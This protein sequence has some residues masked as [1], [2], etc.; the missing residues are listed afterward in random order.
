MK[1][2]V[3][4]I[5]YL[6]ILTFFVT[7]TVFAIVLSITQ[8]VKLDLD[9]LKK[10]QTSVILCYSNGEEIKRKDNNQYVEFRDIPSHVVNSLIAIEDKRFYSHRGVDAKG[11]FRALKNNLFTSSSKQGG[12]TITQQLVK[13][14][15]LSGEKTINRKLKEMRLAVEIERKLT[16]EQILE[17]YLNTVYFG[18]GAYGIAS[19]SNRFFNKN[20][21]ELTIEEGAVLIA[22]LKAPSIYSP[23]KN[24][25]KSKQRRDL[26]LSETY[27][28]GFISEKEYLIAKNKDIIINYERNYEIENVLY[29]EILQDALTVLKLNDISELNGYKI[30]SSI[31]K[32]L[33]NSIKSPADFGIDCDYSIIVTDNKK[34]EVVCYYSNVGDI[35]RCPASTAKPWLIY[36]PAIEENLICPATKILDEKTSFDGYAPSN[37]NDKYYGYVSVKDSLAKSLNIPSIKICNALGTE[38]VKEYAKKLDIEYL[39]N[40]LSVAL[41]NL[42]GGI[43][44]RELTN[45]YSVFSNGGAFRKNSLILRIDNHKGKTIYNHNIATK[46]IFS[47]STAYLIN[48]ILKY[49]AKD[50]TASKLNDL[51]FEVCAK[52]GTNG[53]DKGNLDAYCVAYTTEHTISVWLGNSDGSL[54]SNNITGGSYPTKIAKEILLMLYKDYKPSKFIPPDTVKEISIDKDYYNKDCKIYYNQG[55]E[56]DGVK[57]WFKS[58]YNIEN[59]PNNSKL[60][61]IISY[62]ITCNYCNIAICCETEKDTYYKILDI[63]S[64]ELFNSYY[65][66][67]FVYKAPKKGKYKFI[68]L[69]YKIENG[70][71]IFGE[72]IKLPSVLVE[73]KSDILD[74]DWWED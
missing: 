37:Y 62:K 45:A 66:K 34:G 17:A 53:N 2:V 16:K 58:D 47:N 68:V 4:I 43:T 15:Y 36:A 11:I 41:G 26:I 61:S 49:C 1:K 3:K 24:L 8:S 50:G 18:E 22:C 70:K 7:F 69:P 42:S 13:N 5:S 28:Q 55:E 65:D 35:K 44:L 56:K 6:L 19:A 40:D 59:T 12:S 73:G 63:Y 64:K 32:D 33:Y 51:H 74:T 21:S 57:F 60:P 72:K 29:D 9:K 54:M 52:T 67:D 23:Y 38:K 71:E 14:T 10:G 48:D 39:N 31:D 46:S 30:Y 25:Q 27:K 20:V